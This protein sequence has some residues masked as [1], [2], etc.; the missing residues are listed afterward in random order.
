MDSNFGLIKWTFS[1]SSFF[2]SF[3]ARKCAQIPE[4]M[5]PS[6]QSRIIGGQTAKGP[7]QWH[8]HIR[9]HVDP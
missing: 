7:I 1:Q 2:V 3:L 8:V 4:W 6:M 5:K 9:E